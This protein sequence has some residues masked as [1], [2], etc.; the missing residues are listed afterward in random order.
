M[1]KPVLLGI[2]AGTSSIKVCAFSLEGELLKRESA[3]K[4]IVSR[5]KGQAELDLN[6]YWTSICRCIKSVLADGSLEIMG[7]GLATTCP[8]VVCMDEHFEPIG[9]GIAYLDNRATLQVSQYL[10]KFD[11]EQTYETLIGNRC[12][13]STCSCATMAWIRDNEPERWQKTKHIGMLNSY[14]AAKLTGNSAIDVTQA[15][16]SGIFN[17]ADPTDWND[18]LL[19]KAGIPRNKLLPVASPFE[20]VGTVLPHIASDLGIAPRTKVAIGSG[21]TAAAAFAINFNDASK[22][23]ESAGT[24]GVLTYVTDTPRFNSLFMN[25]CH[26][27]PGKWLSHGANSMMGGAVDWLR[28]NIFTEFSEDYHELDKVLRSSTPGANGVVFLPYLAGERCPIWDT[29]AKGVWYG[30]TIQTQKSD[31]VESVYEAG[32]FSLKQI[33]DLMQAQIPDRIREIVAVG[34]G[35]KSAHWCQMKSDVLQIDYKTTNFADAAAYGAALVGGI[36]SGIFRSVFDEA[37]PFLQPEGTAFFP[38]KDQQLI[39]CY[40]KAYETYIALYPALK[41]IMNRPER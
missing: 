27:F 5:Q 13:I 20:T 34:N 6:R 19:D 28:H 21:D 35:T 37:I 23:F 36:A 33:N 39:N 11:D 29:K 30:L 2:D 16:Y 17:L 10:E 22:A 14:L 31:M 12:S 32:A 8:T 41:S 38:N 1:K 24:S 15:S 3:S 4:N 40:K 9:N 7:I 26:V 25:R 18:M